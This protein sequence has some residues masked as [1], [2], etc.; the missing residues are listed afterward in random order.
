MIR[1][2]KWVLS[3]PS[4][5]SWPCRTSGGDSEGGG[6]QRFPPSFTHL[7]NPLSWSQE[8]Y[9]PVA[10]TQNVFLAERQQHRRQLIA[11]GH[12]N[13][14]RIA[15]LPALRGPWVLALGPGPPPRLLRPFYWGQEINKDTW[16]ALLRPRF[17]ARAS[18][19]SPSYTQS[20]RSGLSRARAL[21][22]GCLGQRARSRRRDVLASLLLQTGSRQ[23]VSV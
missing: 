22:P 23:P 12:P 11:C 20:L 19:P 8:V 18:V 21:L 2:R 14:S 13:C 10:H 9:L 4:Q 5:S 17:Q 6:E 16:P 1:R 7:A 3:E 15:C